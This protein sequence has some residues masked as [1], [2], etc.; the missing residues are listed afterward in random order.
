MVSFRR[1]LEN[2]ALQAVSDDAQEGDQAPKCI[3]FRVF[4][5]L[6]F[7]L[8]ALNE[9]VVLSFFLNGVCSSL[10]SSPCWVLS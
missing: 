9:V 2:Y 4:G 7:R 3:D 5:L 6:G 1:K 8:I 10:G